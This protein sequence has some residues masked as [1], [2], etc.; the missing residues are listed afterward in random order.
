MRFLGIDPGSLGSFCF[1]SAEEI[2]FEPMPLIG[3][4]LDFEK[5]RTI[6]ASAF[7]CHAVL[8]KVMPFKGGLMGAFNYGRNVGALEAMLAAHRI[9][10]LHVAPIAWQ[11][12]MFQGITKNRA[13]SAKDRALIAA[14]KLFP[15]VNL[16]PPGCR[17]PDEGRV[18]SLLLAEYGRRQMNVHPE[19]KGA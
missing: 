18:D 5:L 7:D 12:V 2:V 3:K 11:K 13:E 8:E 6:F 14:R 9:P 4:E 1:L 15:Q 17:V 19:M 16:V 10:Y